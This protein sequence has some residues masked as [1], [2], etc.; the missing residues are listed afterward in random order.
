MND[1]L[2]T[3]HGQYF[4]IQIVAT[5]EGPKTMK[6]IAHFSDRNPHQYAIDILDEP[7]FEEAARCDVKPTTLPEF[8]S[9]VRDASI[10]IADDMIALIEKIKA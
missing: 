1:P 3:I 2:T 6:L 10:E 7:S 8:I 4:D 5:E 9:M